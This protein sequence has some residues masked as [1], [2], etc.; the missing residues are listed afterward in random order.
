[1]APMASPSENTVKVQ[2][3]SEGCV[4]KEPVGDFPCLTKEGFV[5]FVGFVK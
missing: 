2:S 1:M 3:A 4:G 5:S